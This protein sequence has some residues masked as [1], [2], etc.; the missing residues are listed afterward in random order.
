MLD[1]IDEINGSIKKFILFNHY[2]EALIAYRRF[3][4]GKE[5][6]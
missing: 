4:G 6:Q 5:K 3:K 1:I 2:F